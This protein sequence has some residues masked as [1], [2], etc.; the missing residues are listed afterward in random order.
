MVAIYN[1][2]WRI[3]QEMNDLGQVAGDI[4][5]SSETLDI[6]SGVSIY[7]YIYIYIYV[8]ARNMQGTIQIS[9]TTTSVNRLSN[10]PI[11]AN[12]WDK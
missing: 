12:K 1:D 8:E 2:E 10:T 9:P 11:S 4:N 3:E 6:S 7:I 5:S